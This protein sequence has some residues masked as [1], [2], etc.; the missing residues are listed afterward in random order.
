MTRLWSSVCILGATF[1][2]L[3]ALQ[4][5][6]PFER[7]NAA[8]DQAFGALPPW[9]QVKNMFQD[10]QTQEITR[11]ESPLDS[12]H[13]LARAWAAYPHAE[14]MVLM[15]NSQSLMTSLAP[16][17]R[18]SSEPEKTYT[19][20][21]ADSYQHRGAIK[22]FYRL[23]AGALS[24]EEMLWYAAYLA[25]RPEIK[26]AIV[27]VQL[28]YQNFMNA[29]I[30]AGMLELLSDGTFRSIVQQMAAGH[31]ADSDTFVQALAQYDKPQH[32]SIDTP[33]NPRAY[34]LETTLRQ[35]LDRIPTFGRRFEMRA[36]FETMLIRFRTY[37]LHLGSARRRSLGGSRVARSR[38]ALEQLAD[39]C[40]RS[41]IRLILFHAPSNPAVPL[42]GTAE[43]D[44]S[45]HD[46]ANSLAA[47]YSV[48]VLDFEHSIPAGEWGM[49]LNFP[50]PLHLG[51][52]GHK[53]LARLMLAAFAEQGI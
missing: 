12:F 42:Y 41:G 11:G 31:A 4:V 38:A 47:R 23:A 22:P 30:R 49:S 27:L 2:W 29:G 48:T 39:L 17:E 3:G 18:P 37:L 50:D 20:L 10:R 43:D 36:S 6:E 8:M 14:R 15:G 32:A 26:P 9:T 40:G 19:D 45:Y 5:I 24:Y 44:R 53:R 16:G 28:N 46:F 7:M 33:D 35:Q 25:C 13:I 34:E 1:T 52:Q 21:I 51:R